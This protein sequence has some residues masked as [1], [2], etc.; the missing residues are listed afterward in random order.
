MTRGATVGD[1]R[2]TM[3]RAVVFAYHNVGVRCLKVLLAHGVEVALVAD[4]S[5][6]P[7]RADL[8]RE[9]RRDRRRLRH[10]DHYAG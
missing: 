8:V 7:E 3:T 1:E 10:S 6:Q 2:M 5:G 4:P 9:R